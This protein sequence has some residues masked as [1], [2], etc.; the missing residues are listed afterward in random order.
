MSTTTKNIVPTILDGKVMP[1]AV[2]VEEVILGAILL[3]RKVMDRVIGIITSGS[4]FYKES[5]GIVYD[6]CISLYEAGTPID[7]V[8]VSY[9]LKNVGKLEDVGGGYFIS[10]LTNKVASSANIEFHAR[11]VLQSYLQRELIR[12]SYEGLNSGYDDFGDVLRKIDNL[13]DKIDAVNAHTLTESRRINLSCE[14]EPF[15]DIIS[16]Q[17]KSF[18]SIGNVA[19]IVAPP[20]S[21][22]SNVMDAIAGVSVNPNC[23][24][25]GF[26]VETYGKRILHIDT[27]RSYNDAIKGYRRT[28]YRID[29]ERNTHLISGPDIINYDFEMFK[30][31]PDVTLKRSKIHRYIVSEEYKLILIDG[32]TDLMLDPNKLEESQVLISWL[33]AMASKFN[34]AILVTIHDNPKGVKGAPRGHVGSELQRKVEGMLLIDHA[35][36]DKNIKRITNDFEFGKLRNSGGSTDNYFEWK[37][38]M[39][40]S[41]DYKPTK[42]NPEKMSEIKNALDV[43]LVDGAQLTR[44]QIAK[45]LK[46][47]AG[48]SQGTSY[49]WIKIGIREGWIMEE[50]GKINNG[51]EKLL[52]D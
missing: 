37:E 31:V 20:G 25:L 22:K 35:P 33:G 49:E 13:R 7:I 29:G 47:Y 4:V 40:V 52:S 9:Q 34:V 11:I 14:P 5:F 8:T 36:N 1:S 28:F 10:Q 16:F 19:A 21:G 41:T 48:K 15:S 12:I 42:E 26:K 27:E 30:E 32:I 17:G 44:G 24:G 46:E 2:D 39:F 51:S 50:R 3:E 38:H 23:D 43:V 18:L 45:A 6:A